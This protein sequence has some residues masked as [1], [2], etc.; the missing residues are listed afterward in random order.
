MSQTKSEKTR[1]IFDNIKST[2][3][4]RLSTF[5]ANSDLSDV[6]FY[7]GEWNESDG[8]VDKEQLEKI[9]AHK[10]LLSA[11]SIVSEQIT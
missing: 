5:L 11:S 4:E 2:L 6:I 1:V 10:F 8:P 7:V 9:P 3:K